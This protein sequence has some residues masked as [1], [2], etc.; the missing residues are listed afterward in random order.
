M[1]RCE[2]IFELISAELDGALFQEER[3]RLERHLA[4]CPHC[5]ALR[6]ELAAVS[7][8]MRGA[9]EVEPPTELRE[10]IMER[11][12]AQAGAAAPVTRPQSGHRHWGTM[13][14]SAAC[15]AVVLLATLGPARERLTS[16]DK[17]AQPAYSGT[18]QESASLSND[19]P[20]MEDA[21]G[22]LPAE[23][24]STEKYSAGTPE[25]GVMA[26]AMDRMKQESAVTATLFCYGVDALPQTPDYLTEDEGQ[27]ERAWLCP[28]EEL[29]GLMTLL[30]DAE[31]PVTLEKSESYS[32]AAGEWVRIVFVPSEE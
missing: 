11:V 26:A 6:Q 24:A 5:R 9:E 8:V 23:P 3:E 18:L 32:G 4:E 28:A 22:A 15:V 21:D 13:I 19:T 17:E 10:T 30:S 20:P 27:E 2:A 16:A 7:A 25:N 29:Q 12:R 14:A 1:E 31:V